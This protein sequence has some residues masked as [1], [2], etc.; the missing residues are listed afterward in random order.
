MAM[1]SSI[2][3][4]A[5]GNMDVV[6]SGRV[7]DSLVRREGAEGENEQSRKV[8]WAYRVCLVS[9]MSCC[10]FVVMHGENG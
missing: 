5:L 6:K 7:R 2:G 8:R 4:G 10:S 3:S 9:C 1:W